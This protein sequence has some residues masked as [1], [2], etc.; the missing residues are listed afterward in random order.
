MSVFARS[1]KQ[2]GTILRKERKAAGLSQAQLGSMIGSRQATVCQV[3]AGKPG[4]R[5]QTILDL[6]AA[7]GLGLKIVVRRRQSESE[8]SDA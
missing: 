2:L 3:E 6:L 1:S 4:A 8:R 5:I 7:L